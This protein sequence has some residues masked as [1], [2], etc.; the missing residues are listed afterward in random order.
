MMLV[1]DE[2]EDFK[3]DAFMPSILA[4]CAKATR[5]YV[6]RIA[7]VFM[8]YTHAHNTMRSVKLAMSLA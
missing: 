5:K 6:Y 8:V 4:A 1:D 7:L 3:D 2:E